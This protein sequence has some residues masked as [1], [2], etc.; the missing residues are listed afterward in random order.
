MLMENSPMPDFEVNFYDGKFCLNF[1][2]SVP[3]LGIFKSYLSINC[4]DFD[5]VV[6]KCPYIIMEHYHAGEANHDVQ[7]QFN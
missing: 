5:Y 6:L 7:S 1:C 4:W 2:N 3:T